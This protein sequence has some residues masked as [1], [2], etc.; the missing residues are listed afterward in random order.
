VHQ[1]IVCSGFLVPLTIFGPAARQPRF[2]HIRKTRATGIKLGSE[3]TIC[4][5]AEIFDPGQPWR[6]LPPA[7]GKASFRD[8][9]HTRGL[10]GVE[11]CGRVKGSAVMATYFAFFVLIIA[12]FGSLVATVHSHRHTAQTASAL[13][14]TASG[15]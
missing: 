5:V 7:S 4:A 11:E 9:H 1:A 14:V 2:Y 6:F 13:I 15:H 10:L 12:F 8:A 3:F